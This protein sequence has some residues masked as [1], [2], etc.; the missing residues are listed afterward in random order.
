MKPLHLL[1]TSR[2]E[3]I[4]TNS[5]HYFNGQKCSRNHIDRRTRHGHC[6]ECA[7]L[8]R[9][10]N[11]DQENANQ[12]RRYNEMKEARDLVRRLKAALGPSE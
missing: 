5:T 1:P 8:S 3:A 9:L 10:A 6:V 12:R 4:R 7:R 2:E 11:K